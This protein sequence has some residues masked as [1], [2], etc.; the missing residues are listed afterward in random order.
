M[1]V[2][3]DYPMPI[4]LARLVRRSVR[5]IVREEELWNGNTERWG[6]LLSHDSLVVWAFKSRPKHRRRY[7]ALLAARTAAGLGAVRLRSPAATAAWLSGVGRRQPD[8]HS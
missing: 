4:V 8:A 2:W 1:V 6:S 7:P 3:L 5:R